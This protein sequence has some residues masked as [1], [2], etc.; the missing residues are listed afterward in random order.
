MLY[1]HE[2]G[3]EQEDSP[4]DF[5]LGVAA[6]AGKRSPEPEVVGWNVGMKEVSVG[7]RVAVFWFGCSRGRRSEGEAGY[8]IPIFFESLS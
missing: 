5:L 3:T 8:I 6:V 1:S 7:A 2:E 4:G